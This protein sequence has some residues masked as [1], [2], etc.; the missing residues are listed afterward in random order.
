MDFMDEHIS[1][2][3]HDLLYIVDVYEEEKKSNGFPITILKHIF[4]GYLMRNMCH[5]KENLSNDTV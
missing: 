3:F 1:I 4:E 5:K 2:S